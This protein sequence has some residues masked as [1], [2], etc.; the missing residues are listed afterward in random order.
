MSEERRDVAAIVEAAKTQGASV[1]KLA[2]AVG[3][4]AEKRKERVIDDAPDTDTEADG[5]LQG[6]VGRQARTDS[7]REVQRLNDEVMWKDMVSRTLAG[8]GRKAYGGMASL[9]EY[10]RLQALRKKDTW[11]DTTSESDWVPTGYSSEFVDFAR[12]QGGVAAAFPQITI[13]DGMQVM[14]VPG[15]AV[16]A[17]VAPVAETL[18]Y[19]TAGYPTITNRATP[20]AGKL[21]L[22]PSKQS[23]Y[24]AFSMEMLEDAA[25]P[26]MDMART[27]L[28]AALTSSWDSAIINA[29]GTNDS[30]LDAALGPKDA[31]GIYA[32]PYGLR[33]YGLVTKANTTAGGAADLSSDVVQSARVSMGK[34]GAKATDLR[35]IM[36]PEAYLGLL[37]DDDVVT[38]D[39]YGA[40]ATIVTGELGKIFGIP[41]LVTDTISATL[42]TGGKEHASQ[43]TT[44]AILANVT[45]WRVGVKRNIELRVVPAPAHDSMFIY[46][47]A[48]HAFS[49]MGTDDKS[50]AIVVNLATS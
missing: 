45:R 9:P 23:G 48:R 38:V 1:D 25:I 39:K 47:F 7:E 16:A 15:L 2:D 14:E 34:F 50:V 3:R 20:E 32:S 6:I 10:R 35:L 13:P 33:Y 18:A 22:T 36:S 37:G 46:G 49:T 17:T 26:M 5:S 24:A 28:T 19:P 27:E 44:C 30:N 21:T 8:I 31:N 4:L 29:Q 11:L 43:T 40:A 12:V 41:I 42:D